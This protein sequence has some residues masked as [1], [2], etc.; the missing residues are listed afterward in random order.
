MDYNLSNSIN[1]SE[2][3]ADSNSYVMT[4]TFRTYNN[5]Q[6]R[7]YFFAVPVPFGIFTQG[8]DF[9]NHPV[10]VDQVSFVYL[11]ANNNKTFIPNYNYVNGNKSWWTVGAYSQVML[12]WKLRLNIEYNFTAK[13]F[14]KS[15]KP[16]NRFTS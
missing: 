12:P 15:V 1:F 11:Y 2:V 13:A 3:T 9:F 16:Q 5:V 10:D 7:S 14:T 4:Q 6:S 8:L